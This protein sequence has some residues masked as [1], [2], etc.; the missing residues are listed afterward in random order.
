MPSTEPSTGSTNTATMPNSVTV[1]IANAVSLSSASITGATTAIAVPPQ[2]AVPTPINKPSFCPTPNRRHSHTVIPSA[3]AT[4]TTLMPSAVREVRITSKKSS[5]A[6]ISTMPN[7][8]SFVT[9]NRIPGATAAGMPS[10]LRTSMPST[11]ATSIASIGCFAGVP[12]ENGGNGRS[13][14]SYATIAITSASP[15]P[16]TAEFRVLTILAPLQPKWMFRFIRCQMMKSRPGARG[17]STL[18]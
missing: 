11:I 3:T 18:V 6:P 5:R 17:R 13:C 16:G 15:T 12:I 1:V 9:Q 14:S 4:Q 7:A 2:I 8:I 10:V